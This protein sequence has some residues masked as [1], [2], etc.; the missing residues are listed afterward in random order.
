MTCHHCRKPLDGKFYALNVTAMKA[1]SPGRAI[2]IADGE[3]PV[4]L[5]AD[6]GY[7][8]HDLEKLTGS[9]SV[10]LLDGLPIRNV[11][12]EA[13]FCSKRCLAGWFAE[14]INSLTDLSA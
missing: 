3:L 2:M 1:E 10:D 13:S 4:T 6:I 14:K 8:D 7:H 5:S 9:A 11:Q 12:A